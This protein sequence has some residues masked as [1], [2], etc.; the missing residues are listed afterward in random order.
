[1]KLNKKKTLDDLKDSRAVSKA[2]E[3]LRDDRTRGIVKWI[4]EIIV[5]VVFAVLVAISAFQTVTLQESAMEP[6]YSVGEKF[7]VNRAV[8]KIK[9]PKRGDVIVFRTS[10]SDDAAL[11]IRRVIGLP[12]E[13]VLIKDGQVYINGKVYE[14]NGAYP[15]ITNAGLA[16]SSITLESGE[17][18]VLGDNR[19]N[20][21]D[22]RF[23]DI[24]NINKKYI[25]GKLWFTVS[26]KS[27][28]GFVK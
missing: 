1:M 17:Y 24:G 15:D 14:E 28:I 9:S 19:N 10:V 5:T 12:G 7:F 18:F 25:V 26:P 4:F 2:R 27:K 11:H 13:T 21:E 3:R 16:D 22:S 23:S 20:S 6:T 8:Y